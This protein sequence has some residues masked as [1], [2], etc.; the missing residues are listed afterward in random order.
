MVGT[1]WPVGQAVEA[2]ASLVAAE[3]NESNN[4]L[5]TGLETYSVAGRNVQTIAESGSSVKL[6]HFVYFKEVEMRANLYWSVASVS[7]FYLDCLF[8]CV[9]TRFLSLVA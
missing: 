4:F 2:K 5:F 7:N 3:L 6:E 1:V 8:A 9:L